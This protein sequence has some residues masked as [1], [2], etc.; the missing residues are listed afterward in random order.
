M[1]KEKIVEILKRRGFEKYRNVWE[2]ET[3]DICITVEV[4]EMSV[5]I[6]RKGITRSI[7]N[8][9][10]NKLKESK[11]K[12]LTRIPSS[13]VGGRRKKDNIKSKKL[14]EKLIEAGDPIVD[15]TIISM[16]LKTGDIL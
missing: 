6:Y 7:W 10:V 2:K 4:D 16:R 11:F 3:P 13:S 15:E 1:T 5:R 14:W 12:K 9:S 8:L